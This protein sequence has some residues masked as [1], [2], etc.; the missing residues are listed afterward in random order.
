MKN[1]KIFLITLLSSLILLGLSGASS[2]YDPLDINGL[3]ESGLL[4]STGSRLGYPDLSYGAPADSILLS[5][6]YNSYLPWVN[7]ISL[8]VRFVF[9]PNLWPEQDRGINNMQSYISR[10]GVSPLGDMKF[11]NPDTSYF[12]TSFNPD[13]FGYGLHISTLFYDSSVELFFWTGSESSPFT[14][15]TTSTFNSPNQF[16]GQTTALLQLDN[17][18]YYSRNR[19]I[20]AAWSTDL[21]FLGFIHQ[22]TAP[23]IRLET[24]YR[25]DEVK[26]MYASRDT[27]NHLGEFDELSVGLAYKGKNNFEL[28]DSSY[29]I[30]WGFGYSYS[31]ALNVPEMLADTSLENFDTGIRTHSGNI[32]AST[33]WNNMRLMTMVMYLY[34][35]QSKGAMT[36][37]Q[38]NF[39]PDWRWTYGIRANFYDGAGSALWPWVEESEHISF[40]VTYK[41]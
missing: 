6:E 14:S 39:S 21:S 33:Y 28:L 25:S 34:D 37:M 3:K 2:A 8:R 31:R 7:E 5:K 40:S 38:A 16:R 27:F 15:L 9:D 20:A 32:N 41:W 13:D 22:G 23:T 30:S 29:G 4:P 11:L 17:P 36:M 35:I 26:S 12:D 1:L 24:S 10:S 19:N 18:E